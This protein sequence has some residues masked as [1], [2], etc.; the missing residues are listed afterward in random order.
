MKAP[1]GGGAEVASSLTVIAEVVDRMDEFK[2]IN[3]CRVREVGATGSC[4][5][6]ALN[7]CMRES[8][9]RFKIDV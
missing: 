4:L 1:R 2:V 8:I 3:E 9:V 5:R 6:H 7:V